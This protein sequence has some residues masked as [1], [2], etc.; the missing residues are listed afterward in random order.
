M[1]VYDGAGRHRGDYPV[2]C[3]KSSLLYQAFDWKARVHSFVVK[4]RWSFSQNNVHMN[5]F[6]IV[7]SR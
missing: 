6:S 4:R 1:P 2:P 7:L 3:E 5:Q